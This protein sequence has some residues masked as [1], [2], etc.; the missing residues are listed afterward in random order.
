MPTLRRGHSDPAAAGEESHNRSADH[1][2]DTSV[3][4]DSVRDPSLR[5]G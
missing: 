1:A 4:L 2:E 3:T 5:S